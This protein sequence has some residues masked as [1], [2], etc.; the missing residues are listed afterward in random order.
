MM[1]LVQQSPSEHG[2]PGI[3]V[4]SAFIVY[5][6][7]AMVFNYWGYLTK[8]PIFLLSALIAIILFLPRN[9]NHDIEVKN[10]IA[11]RQAWLDRENLTDVKY[12]QWWLDKKIKDGVLD[13]AS[14]KTPI[15]IVASEG[16]GIRNLY[17]T[18]RV[19]RTLD[20]T[21]PGFYDRTF[22]ATGVSGGGV[23]LGF[24]YA[25]MAHKKTA[26][27]KDKSEEDFWRAMDI[28]TTK[29]HLSRPT[30]YLLFWDLLQRFYWSPRSSW[31]RSHQLAMSFSDAYDSAIGDTSLSLKNDLL[32]LSSVPDGG[33]RPALL[34]NTILN[35]QGRKAVYST[36]PISSEYYSDAVDLISQTCRSVPIREAMLSVARFPLISGPGKIVRHM[37]DGG[38]IFLGNNSDG[39]GFE[40]DGIQTAEQTAIM[41]KSVMRGSSRYEKLDVRI[42]FIGTDSNKVER[43]PAV[44]QEPI[45]PDSKTYGRGYEFAWVSGASSTVF[46]WVI[47]AHRLNVAL[48]TGLSVVKIGL[49]TKD[50]GKEYP[51][52]PLGWYLS[53]SA[54]WR[55]EQQARPDSLR[56]AI[57]ELW[58]KLP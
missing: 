23:G 16:G 15:Y 2:M 30:Y 52:L 56:N 18:Y 5:T 12:A 42:L 45:V 14:C 40:N 31:D 46:N 8:L 32:S 48:D 29:D 34:F 22:A 43:N 50:K 41:L 38:Q 6:S 47:S 49:V 36:F 26:L 10:D 25:A 39:G 21:I 9:N 1:Y 3:I 37:D 28:A 7:M 53:S 19:L 4:L 11:D 44:H 57:H 35:D 24:Y 20:S 54:K 51:P 17:W 58:P 13:T 33:G 55:I 27:A